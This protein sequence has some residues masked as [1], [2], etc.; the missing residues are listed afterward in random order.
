MK[1]VNCFDVAVRAHQRFWLPLTV[2]GIHV[3]STLSL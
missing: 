2:V 3:I 1:P